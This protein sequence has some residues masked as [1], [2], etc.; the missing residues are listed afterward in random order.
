MM[1]RINQDVNFINRVL[2]SDESTFCT[3]KI[4]LSQLKPN[5]L[6]KTEHHLIT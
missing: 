4:G 6:N 3:T 5:G 1:H 2:F